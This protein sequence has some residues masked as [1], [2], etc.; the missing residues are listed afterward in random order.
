MHRILKPTGSIY[1][2]C[3][4]TASHYLKIV[5]DAVF[6][7]KNFRNEIVWHYKGNS[8]PKRKFPAKHDTIL[9]YASNKAIFNPILVPYAETTLKRY[10]HTDEAGR[11][12]KIS[13][14][15]E[16]KQEK[17]Y[18]AEGKMADSVW[19]I[20]PI[21]KKT[22][23]LGYPTQKPITLYERII[24]AS[25][26]PDDLVLDPFAGCGTTIEAARKNNRRAIGIDILPF[27]LR[28]INQYRLAPKGL[29]QMPVYGVP[30]DFETASNLAKSDPYKFQDWAI[31]LIDGLASNPKKSGDEGIDGFGVLAHKPNNMDRKAIVV[32]VTGASGAPARQ[33][34][35]VYRRLFA[36]LTPQW[37]SLSRLTRNLYRAGSITW[38]PCRWAKHDMIRYNVSLSRITI[39][40]ANDMTNCSPCHHLQTRGQV[41]RCS[42]H[43]LT[44][45]LLYQNPR[46]RF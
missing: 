14:L 25:S 8:T 35:N 1:L 12:Y 36:I 22:E 46:K 37:V 28:L 5:M 23:R 40:S 30:V 6:G 9:Y 20:P 21:R 33:S 38:N 31:S 32:Q 39:G 45:N 29:A 13:A 41:N 27:A 10:N 18:M 43:F 34:L 17:V 15:R 4:P 24:K 19:D 2:H 16:G 11:R 3:D 42:Q 26:K 44:I 7:E